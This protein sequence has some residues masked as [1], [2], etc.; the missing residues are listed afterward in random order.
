MRGEDANEQHGL[1]RRND[2]EAQAEGKGVCWTGTE[3]SMPASQD[4]LQMS[5]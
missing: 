4:S 5:R 1:S 3:V 2:E